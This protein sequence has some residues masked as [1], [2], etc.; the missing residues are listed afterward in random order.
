MYLFYGNSNVMNLLPNNFKIY[1][2]NS[3]SERG[4]PMNLL[5]PNTLGAINEYDFDCRY[6]GLIMSNEPMFM[7]LM[8]L[9]MDL[10]NGINVFVMVQ[11]DEQ[12]FFDSNNSAWNTILIESLFKFIQQ[13]Y[14]L[15][16]T[17]INSIDDINSANETS[18][19]DYGLINLEEDKER[20]S[21][22]IEMNRIMSGGLPY[23]QESVY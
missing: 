15:N 5:P 17:L 8:N 22:N 12:S 4:I 2:F 13:R 16:G 18:F 20:W 11:Y 7:N 1:N 10:Y 6:A 14:G 3:L 9:I 23:G 21:Y 19:E